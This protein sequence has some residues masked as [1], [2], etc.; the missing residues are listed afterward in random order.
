MTVQYDPLK[1]LTKEFLRGS[2]P[3]SG[4]KKVRKPA[5]ALQKQKNKVLRA[6]SIDLVDEE[7]D[8]NPDNVTHCKKCQLLGHYLQRRPY[9]DVEAE[10]LSFLAEMDEYVDCFI[11]NQNYMKEVEGAVRH[12]SA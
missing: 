11:H 3:P 6:Y 4:T 5:P 8:E 1:R 9:R 7:A 10:E 12:L 2:W